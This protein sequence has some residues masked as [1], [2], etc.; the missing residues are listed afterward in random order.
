MIC[1][2]IRLTPELAEVGNSYHETLVDPAGKS[3]DEN[4]YFTGTVQL[5]AGR[6]QF[7][8]AHWSVVAAA[9]PVAPA[10]APKAKSESATARKKHHKRR[11]R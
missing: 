4:G 5:N 8:D 10:A 7:R 3:T 11:H 2:W 1:A 6:W 9:A